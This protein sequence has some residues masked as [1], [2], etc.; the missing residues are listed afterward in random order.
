MNSGA[1]ERSRAHC[2]LGAQF[3]GKRSSVENSGRHAVAFRSS[4]GASPLGQ[5][6]RRWLWWLLLP[7]V[8][9]VV[10]IVAP[11]VHSGAAQ[12]TAGPASSTGQRETIVQLTDDR[13]SAASLTRYRG[14]V[15][16]LNLW[17]SWCPP[18]RAEM[19]ELQRFFVQN[20]ARGV[21]V[22]GVNEGESAERASE[23]A[24][25]LGITFPIWIDDEQRY[26]RVYAALGLPTTIVIDRAGIVVRGF[27][28]PVTPS[29]LQTVVAKIPAH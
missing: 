27:D 25:S 8:G 16:V 22:I 4:E 29:D 5:L 7:L 15:V 2:E 24:H 1:E 19:P 6:D 12:S 21:V 14:R 3:G 26:G 9:I 28:G 23:F 20:A 11:F 10:A 17:A 18:C 13:G